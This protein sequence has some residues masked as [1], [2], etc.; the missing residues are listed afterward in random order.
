MT[1]TISI[2]ISTSSSGSAIKDAKQDVQGLGDAASK[3]SGG[4]NVLKEVATGA[5]RFVGEAAVQ[6]AA[7]LGQFIKDSITGAG[8]FESGMNRFAAAAGDSLSAA[9]L[10]AE[11]FKQIFLDI[12]KELPVSTADVQEAAIT[13]VKGGL[14]PAILAAGGLTDA[15]Q[16]A[17]AAE[18]D[19]ADAAELSIKQL[20]TFGPVTGTAAEQT[21]FLAEAQDLLVK[22]AGAST[23]DVDRLGDAMLTAAGAAKGAGL[24]Y[25]DFVTT[26]G[27][28]S[29][30]FG[31]A[32]EAGTSF[33]NLLAR[34]IPS[35][36][37]AK[38]KM[39]ELGLATA[40]GTSLFYDASGQFIGMRDAAEL[41]QNAFV[42]LSDAE[43]TDAL[44]TIFGNDAKGAAIAL[45]DAGSEQYDIFAGKM[46]A[47]SGVMATAAAKQEGFNTALDNLKGSIEVVQLTIGGAL[48]P[49][50][51]DLLDNV[52]TPGVNTVMDLVQAV[53]GSDEAFNK[54]APDLQAAI[55]VI[56]AVTQGFGEGGLLGAL[57]ALI[58]GI[59]NT[60]SSFSAMTSTAQ[61]VFDA[62]LSTG[63]MVFGTLETYIPAVMAAIQMYIQSYL[64][65]IMAFW[66]AHGSEVMAFVQ[67][68][69][70]TVSTIINTALELVL[71][72]V[73]GALAL[74][75]GFINDHGTEIQLI[76]T[77]AWETISNVISGVLAV[78]KGLLQAALA[79]MQGDWQGAWE[80][81]QGASETF[82]SSIA[83]AIKGF[84]DMIA[85]FFGTSL[86]GIVDLWASNIGQLITIVTTTD[87]ASVGSSIID[88]IASGISSAAQSLANAAAQAARDALDAAK[89]ALGISSPSQV[90][91][92]EVGKPMAEGMAL[93]LASGAPM[94]A[95]AAGYAASAGVAGAQTYNQ[96]RSLTYAPTI[97]NYGQASDGLDYQMA[98]SLA[99]V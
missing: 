51:T 74:I 9:G 39:I 82:V 55:T 26:M 46:D 70:T 4:F 6:A 54:L 59:T 97:N 35:T 64:D 79:V 80:A 53:L 12:G 34:M 49:I 2:V 88:G 66:D 16:F 28:I 48:L 44:N 10:E 41:L 89:S 50:L 61:A 23:L 15:I 43:R 30:S 31:S 7:G 38:D 42:G 32:A 83:S 67:T 33:K 91:A 45:I 93:G 85:G 69:W 40:D 78:I 60:G 81:I 22:A 73:T 68:T 3:S 62:L 27:L 25:E 84:L 37:S 94:V 98:R 52:I 56:N 19:L 99:G 87:W 96:Q 76:L 5:L 58:P 21:A 92:M 1:A 18:M 8:D 29:P 20:G 13:L 57:N 77:G 90:F 71:S 86:Q 14:D 11:D 72:I 47:A 65:Q 24:E 17:A 63:Q 75:A 36:E 95:G